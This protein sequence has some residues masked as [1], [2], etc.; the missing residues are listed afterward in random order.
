MSEKTFWQK[1]AE[2]L[3]RLANWPDADVPTEALV[4]ELIPEICQVPYDYLFRDDPVA[5]CECSL[6]TQEYFDID[7]MFA[8]M[9]CYDFEA[10]AMGASIIFKPDHCPDFDRNN[11]F[12]KDEKD[13]D[14][15]KFSGLNTGRFPY[16]I[17]YARAYK[18]YTGIDMFP[19]LSAPWTLAGNLYGVDNLIMS[20][21]EDPDFVKEMLRRIVDDF[22]LPLYRE[23]SKLFPEVKSAFLPDAFTSIP[24]VSMNIIDEFIRPN[25]E[26]ERKAME[27]LGYFTGYTAF[28][29][30]SNLA[31]GL[32]KP[33]IEFVIWANGFLMCDDPDLSNLGP[34]ACRKLADEYNTALMTGLD[35]PFLEFAPEEE[36]IAR[37]KEIML[38]CKKG[39]TPL[40][41]GFNCLNPKADIRKMRNAIHAAR[42]YGRPDAREENVFTA[43]AYVSFVEF[44]KYKK[45]HNL[46]GYGFEWLDKS[47][48]KGLL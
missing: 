28:F 26:Y 31:Q 42:F 21:I 14:K 41:F 15:I 2:R 12:I 48:L 5:M 27:E 1:S 40:T 13:L 8:N 25:M 24:M 6:L 19:Q 33:Y 45:E 36:V 35:A 17:E 7:Q 10:E 22:H 38:A 32:Q 47:G 23:L 46:E 18:K 3:G 37:V 20:T 9:D 39:S 16:L 44:L 29:G 4:T 34:Q 11:F 30:F 43:P